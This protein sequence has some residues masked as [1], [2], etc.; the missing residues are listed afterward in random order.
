ML[1]RSADMTKTIA[2]LNPNTSTAT[3]QLMTRICNGVA[4]GRAAFEGHTMVMG[5]PVVA[6]EKALFAAGSQIITIGENLAAHG[7]SGLLIAGFGDPGLAALRL[8]V[9]IPVTG[10]AEAGIAEAAKANRRFSIITTTPDLCKAIH[11]KVE[12][13]HALGC[14]ASLRVTTGDFEETMG[15]IEKMSAALLALANQCIEDDGAEAILI[16]GGPL[17]PAAHRIAQ[18]ISVPIVEP[19]KA[20]AMLALDRCAE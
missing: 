20:G 11:R 9:D 1:K 4:A 18:E 6:D 10:I 16:G 5:P 19:V 17:A 12:E 15:N 14:L 13:S 2:L 8:R 7:V 3:T